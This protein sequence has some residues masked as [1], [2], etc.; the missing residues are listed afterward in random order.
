MTEPQDAAA[1][2]WWTT[3]P[4]P[5]PDPSVGGMQYPPLSLHTDT[6]RAPSIHGA[7]VYDPHMARAVREGISREEA[8]RR[9]MIDAYSPYRPQH[10]M[11]I[12]NAPSAAA[13]SS[14]AVTVIGGGY[15]RPFNHTL[16]LILTLLTCGLWLPV[17]V[18]LY[19]LHAADRRH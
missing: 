2:Q 5:A 17:W 3:P 15:H 9:N 11:P 18:L 13:S 12:Y 10:P 1:S 7:P 16:H 8:K 14:A 19:L 6:P 4:T